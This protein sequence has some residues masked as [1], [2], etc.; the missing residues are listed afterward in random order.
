MKY[1]PNTTTYLIY[2]V[3]I[4]FLGYK[5]FSY[6]NRFKYLNEEITNIL[7]DLKNH[8]MVIETSEKLLKTVMTKNKEITIHDTDKHIDMVK[9][10]CKEMNFIIEDFIEKHRLGRRYN[11][12]KMTRDDIVKTVN[13]VVYTIKSYADTK[14]IHFEINSQWTERN[15]I[16]DEGKTKRILLNIL[17]N[18]IKYSSENDKIK[19]YIRE[20]NNA[21]EISVKDNGEG[22]AKEEIP[23]IF[24]KYYRIKKRIF[25]SDKGFG[26]GLYISKHFARLQGGDL[27]VNSAKGEGSIFTLLLPLYTNA[28]WNELYNGIY[29]N[30]KNSEKL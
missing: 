10:N 28:N 16:F 7:H 12:T 19:I 18:A 26:I 9:R 24:N 1:V 2:T 14:N 27:K 23:Y 3:L 22:I 11:E 6:K 30:S 21:L 4:V 15:L 29:T 25:E 5:W 17:M 20:N 8:G 13:S